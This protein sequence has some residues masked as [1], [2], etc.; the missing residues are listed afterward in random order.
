MLQ[1]TNG[2]SC[3]MDQ[4]KD[5]L[6]ISFVQQVPEIGEDGETN[7]VKVEEVVNLVM[8]KVLAQKLLDGLVEMLTDDSTKEK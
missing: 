4:E 8:G 5:E 6:M 3:A 7:H 1:Y 2:F